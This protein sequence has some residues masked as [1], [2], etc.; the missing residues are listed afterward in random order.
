MIGLVAAYFAAWTA[1]FVFI[2]FSRGETPPWDLYWSYLMMAWTFRAGE[3][4]TFI[5]LFSVVAFVP[6]ATLVVFVLW[7]YGRT[8]K[9]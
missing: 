7:W 3:L 1:S 6:L 2:F 5:W 9:R 4:P 8:R